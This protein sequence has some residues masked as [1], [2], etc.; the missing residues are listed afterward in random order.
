[1]KKQIIGVVT[2]LLLDIIWVSTF[3]NTQYQNMVPKIQCG[4]GMTPNLTYAA[5]S[6]FLMVI[7]LVVFVLPNINKDNLLMDSLLYGG[8]FGVVLY[9][10][11]DLT[12][13]A[14]INNWDMKLGLIDIIWG[15]FVMFAS[16]MVGG[17]FSDS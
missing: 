10:V 6:Y 16:A 8:L 5:M 3:M 7:G 17:Y 12:A 4:V 15:G 2:L 14:V 9:G 1:M 13:A 11:Y